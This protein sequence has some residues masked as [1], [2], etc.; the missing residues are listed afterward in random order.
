VTSVDL[1]AFRRFL[2][3]DGVAALAVA[4]TLRPTEANRLSV[5]ANLR[6][7]FPP[8]LAAAAVETVLLRHKAAAKFTHAGKLFFTRE[9]LEMASGEVVAKHRAERFRRFG[10]VGDFACGIGA[11]TLALA[12]GCFVHAIDRDELHTAITTANL[13]ALRMA[14]RAAV[15]TADLLADPLPDVPAAF[16][17]PGRRSDGRRFLRLADYQPAPAELLHRLPADFPIAFKLAPG[18][19][20]AELAAFDGEAEFISAGGELKECVLWLNG[21]RTAGRRATVLTAAG[22]HTL[23]A[24]T[25]MSV[26]HAGPIR[27][28]LLD[29]NA[30][31]VRAGL[32]PLLGERLGATGT[33]FTVQML[34]TD[35]VPDTPFAAAYRVEAVLP[36]DVRTVAA[37]LRKRAVGR[38]TPVMRGSLLTAD[39][40]VKGLKLKGTEHRHL[41][42]TREVGKQVAVV[43]ERLPTH[44]GPDEV[45]TD[46]VAG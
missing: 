30:A 42:L 3:L 34:T 10:T 11:D 37:E 14:D 32:V 29:P 19:D 5:L 28:V 38:V 27:G 13:R 17:D 16:A 20:V 31:V 18:V 44:L 8:D 26:T 23:A 25:A 22:P 40:F 46:N 7:R 39:E 33:D 45:S 43:A 12:D 24:D 41:F 4:M 36:A 35:A 9:G 2:T 6:K 15:H 1:P 21:L